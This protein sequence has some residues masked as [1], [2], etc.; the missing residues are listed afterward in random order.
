MSTALKGAKS[1][2]GL[3]GDENADFAPDQFEHDSWGYENN[4]QKIMVLPHK[5]PNT[6][7]DN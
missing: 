5:E 4:P 2:K 7:S 6:V 3:P 1:P